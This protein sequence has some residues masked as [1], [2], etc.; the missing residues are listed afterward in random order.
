MNADHIGVGRILCRSIGVARG[1]GPLPIETPPMTKT[2]VKKPIIF[3]FLLVLSRAA[4]IN[5]NI[6]N[7]RPGP[8]IQIFANQI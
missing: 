3:Q 5:I 7:Q 6:D 4:V 1:P 8:S 2:I